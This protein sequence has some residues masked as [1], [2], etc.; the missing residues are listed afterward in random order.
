MASFCVFF[1]YRPTGRLSH[2]SLPLECHRKPNNSEALRFTRG[3]LQRSEE[4][5]R[6][7]GCQSSSVE[8][9]PQC[10]GLW[11]SARSLSHSPSAPPPSFTQSPYPPR[12]HANSFVIGPAVI[13]QVLNT[14]TP[15][16]IFCFRIVKPRTCT[17]NSRSLV[18]AVSSCTCSI[19][20]R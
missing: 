14:H 20:C 8:D 6:T 18:S 1:F 11:H 4:Q 12:S 9:Q 13:K 5:S 10:P 17:T 16:S 19:L 2:T 15:V 7:G 3:I